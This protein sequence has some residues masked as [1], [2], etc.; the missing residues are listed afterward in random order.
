MDVDD[1]NKTG[2]LDNLDSHNLNVEPNENS[3]IEVK[4]EEKSEEK[5]EEKKHTTRWQ[6]FT[7]K[8][9]K[10]PKKRKKTFKPKEGESPDDYELESP[11]H[12]AEAS[13]TQ[14]GM[15]DAVVAHHDTLEDKGE[16]NPLNGQ[17]DISPTTRRKLRKMNT[18]GMAHDKGEEERKMNQVQN[19]SK[20]VRKGSDILGDSIKTRKRKQDKLI[21]LEKTQRENRIP[22][23]TYTSGPT[24]LRVDRKNPFS[25]HP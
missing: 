9:E 18:I 7:M 21:L 12:Q 10:S 17:G 16:K 14:S 5:L 20:L 13:L 23:H 22:F 1:I 24:P 8:R 25:K 6:G 3:Q 11:N 2:T 15:T 19:S 4:E